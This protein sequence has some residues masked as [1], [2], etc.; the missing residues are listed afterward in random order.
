MGAVTTYKWIN[1]TGN[2]VEQATKLLKIYCTLNDINPS[3]TSLLVCAYI[4]VYGYSEQTR[5]EILEAGIIGK[6]SS[7]QQEIYK[8]KRMGLLEGNKDKTRISAKVTLSNPQPLTP[9]TVII[10]NLDNR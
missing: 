6:L 1:K 3:E 4:M 10:I 2:R 9:Q 5:E 8:I 7:L